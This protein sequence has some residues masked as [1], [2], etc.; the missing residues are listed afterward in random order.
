M[1][2]VD[3][4]TITSERL[5]QELFRRNDDAIISLYKQTNI[6]GGRNYINLRRWKG[7]ETR[8]SGLC[9]ELQ[10]SIVLELFNR[11]QSPKSTEDI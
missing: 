1:S 8:C 6:N 11:E 5:I 3:L 10:H 2:D 4:T 7:D 9:A